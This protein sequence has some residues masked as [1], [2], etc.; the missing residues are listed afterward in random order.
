MSRMAIKSPFPG[1]D[2]WL[3]RRWG[4]VHQRLVTYAADALQEVLPDD[5]RARLEE[6]VFVEAPFGDRSIFPDVRV[7]EKG[8]VPGSP[9]SHGDTATAEPL[10]LDLDDEP[11]SQGFIEII[12]SG[13]GGRVVS[14]I[15]V[16][17]PSNKTPGTGQDLYLKKQRELRDGGVSLVEIDLLRSGRRVSPIPQERLPPDYRTAYQVC[18]TR[19]WRRNK[20]E[21]YRVPLRDPLPSINVP[22]R[23]A[24]ADVAMNLQE[25]IEKVYRNARYDD[26]QYGEDAWPALEGADGQWADE[27]LKRAGRR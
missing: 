18:A 24:D 4:D 10:I 14:V 7:L 22:L 9:L 19:G 2:P 17:S 25:L 6:R 1:M 20:I 23:E 26:L 3:E 12:D 8:G 16:L 21:V 13:S 11:T 15:E 5:L 27:I